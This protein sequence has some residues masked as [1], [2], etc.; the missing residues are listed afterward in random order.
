MSEFWL[1]LVIALFTAS[2]TYLGVPVAERFDVPERMISGALQFAAGI[3]T[4][5][6]GLSLMP[7]AVRYGTPTGVVLAFFV[8]GALFVTFEYASARRLTARPGGATQVTSL[9]LYAGVLAD[10]LI[11]GIVIGIGSTLTLMTGVLLGVGIAT[12]TA[13]LAFVTTATAKQ[14]GIPPA[15]RRLLSFLYVV[16]IVGGALLGYG[17]LREQSLALRLTLIAFASGFLITTVTQSLIPEANKEGEPGFAGILF[18]AGLSL[19]ALLTLTI[20]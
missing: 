4:A 2:L 13:P 5:L 19:Y 15:Q 20:I 12:S 14:Q 6:V 3:I 1:V 10:M 18:I 16:C 17:L 9:G 11:D 7:P 8:G